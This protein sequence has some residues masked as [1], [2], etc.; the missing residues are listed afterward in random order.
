MMD[1]LRNSSGALPAHFRRHSQRRFTEANAEHFETET[2]KMTLNS[3]PKLPDGQRLGIYSLF[4]VYANSSDINANIPTT[5]IRIDNESL[6]L[7][8][9]NEHGKISS[10]PCRDD[11]FFHPLETKKGATYFYKTL[12]KESTVFN[13]RKSAELF[14]KSSKDWPALIQTCIQSKTKPPSVTRALWRA[15]MKTRYYTI[16]N[17]QQLNQDPKAP[18][19]CTMPS[20][21]H[22]K[23][24][25]DF[26]YIN[27]IHRTSRSI[28]NPYKVNVTTRKSFDDKKKLDRAATLQSRE[29]PA[30]DPQENLG[31]QNEL[32][33][34]TRAPENLLVVEDPI[35]ENDLEPLVD[36]IIDF[37]NINIY[38]DQKLIG[39][40]LDFIR[41]Q[42]EQWFLLDCKE[43]STVSN[44]AV[45]KNK[46][47][48]QII[49]KETRTRLSIDTTKLK[50]K[51][52][53]TETD[54]DIDEKQS[55]P[56]IMRSPPPPPSPSMTKK[57]AQDL[58]ER[59]NKINE[60]LES[61]ISKSLPNKLKNASI[62][63]QSI[64]AY[65][66]RLTMKNSMPD[67]EQS[68][69]NDISPLAPPTSNSLWSDE[70]D[71]HI[72]KCLTDVIEKFEEMNMNKE[73]LKVKKQ[74]LIGKYGGDE[75]WTM[76][77]DSL[78]K[79]IM[80]TGSPLK[81]H[82]LSSDLSMITSGMHKVFNGCASLQFR[83][84]IKAI[85]ENMGI[86]ES[87]FAIYSGFF[88]DTLNEFNVEEGDKEM[89][90][91]QIRLMKSLIC[92][93]LSQQ[94]N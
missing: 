59:W 92:Q 33:V 65:Q 45:I 71:E 2:V 47:K 66:T 10:R 44:Y 62:E 39:I 63:E 93:P 57:S 77:I 40:V 38:K 79:K 76:F 41:N 25:V 48:A 37:L 85:H 89:I 91:S 20:M 11:D 4:A 29:K 94:S 8:K 34:N 88:E 14:W 54:E 13:S 87:E 35:K 73:L 83:R 58:V 60:K 82:F 67:S 51:S 74:N 42:D 78:Y 32:I 81:K 27:M 3:L 68:S 72:N 17:R 24:Q 86:L 55:C 21:Y 36:E 75:F 31:S 19:K 28:N 69:V 52:H 50:F 23:S 64:K 70:K 7:L 30:P 26:K 80:S 9:T 43:I 6:Y 1:E 49:G 16:I 84:K 15:G 46:R 53:K 5:L 61:V 22:R 18:K 12:Y 90:M 56:F